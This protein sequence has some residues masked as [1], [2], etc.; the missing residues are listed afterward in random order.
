MLYLSFTF[1]ISNL[2]FHFIFFI[3]LYYIYLLYD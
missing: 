3:I 1:F 2:T